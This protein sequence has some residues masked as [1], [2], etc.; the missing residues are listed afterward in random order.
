MGLT[1]NTVCIGPRTIFKEDIMW[2]KETIKNKI[3]ALVLTGIGALSILPE[4]KHLVQTFTLFG[5]PSIIALTLLKFAD[6]VLL[7]CL[8]E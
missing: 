1:L 3:Y 2:S 5:V 4:R 6:H 8:F 7:L